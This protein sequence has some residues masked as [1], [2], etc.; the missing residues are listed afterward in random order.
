MYPKFWALPKMCPKF[1]ALPK[2]CPKLYFCTRPN[3]A[4]LSGAFARAMKIK[5]GYL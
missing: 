2:K 3:Q 5:G 1:W 4:I